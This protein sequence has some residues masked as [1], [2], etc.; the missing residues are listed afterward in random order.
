MVKKLSGAN[1]NR[2]E[3]IGFNSNFSHQS[4]DPPRQESGQ[5]ELWNK[6]HIFKKA[7]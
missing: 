6:N 3:K 5:G 1:I 4:P 7:N 2:K